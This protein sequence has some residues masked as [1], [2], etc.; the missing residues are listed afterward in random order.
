MQRAK[1]I[2]F[3]FIC[4]LF[5]QKSFATHII[6]GEIFYDCTGGNNYKITMKV[7]RDC[8]N[9]I[10][11]PFDVPASVF[12]FDAQGNFIDSLEMI[13]PQI[14]ILPVTINNPCASA[15]V[16]ICVEEAIYSANI[17]LPNKA[18]GYDIVYQRCCR[19]GTILNLV[20]PGAVGS[21]FMTHIPDP[22]LALCNSSPRFKTFP[23][24]FLCINYPLNYD[25]SAI[26]PDGDSL[27]YELC[28]PYTGLSATC[29]I[30]GQAAVAAGCPGIPTPPPYAFVP[31]S[32][33]YTSNNPM[34]ANPALNIN[35]STGLM[36]GTPNML[37]QWVVGVCVKEY[38]K[39]VLIN[40]S[41]RDFQFNVTNC[42]NL[43]VAA[44]ISQTTFC[45]GYNV[46]FN[47][48]STNAQ[49]F[50][51]DFGVASTS[52]DTSNV[53]NPS[54]T[55]ADSGTYTVTLI[56]NPNTP[57]ADTQKSSFYIYP[58]LNP[59]LTSPPG[60][61]FNGHTFNLTPGGSFMG[62]GSTFNWNFG[63]NATPTTSSAQNPSN[64]TFNAP[65]TYTVSLTVTENGCTKTVTSTINVFPQPVAHFGAD[66][67]VGCSMQPISFL[68]SSSTQPL[69]YLWNFGNGTTSTL[70]NPVI[71][72]NTNGTY[73]VSLIVT[74]SDG[75]KDTATLASPITTYPSPVAGFTVNPKDTTM[76]F[77]TITMYDASTGA[78]GCTVFWGDGSSGINCNDVH[79][80]TSPG[81][82]LI[83]QVV[84]NAN[85]C[86]DTA[87]S[88][89]LIRPEFAFWIPNA[90]TPNGNGLNDVFKPVIKGVSN[91][92]FLIF[93]R[94]GE[95]LFET[96]NINVGWDG[97][98]KGKLCT[99][100][101][102]VYKVSFMDDE[103][104]TDKQYIGN[105][106]LVR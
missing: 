48:T 96:N 57:C 88:T 42:P 30:L 45:F 12:I 82:Y 13:S 68:D 63:A 73:S 76:A 18:G 16:G 91:Y 53:P 32:S 93:D 46:Q 85:G 69:T 99:N 86:Y 64:V 47:Q 21:T 74:N 1:K 100:D 102:Y 10:N 62:N 49:T 101:V 11:A 79:T 14:K 92:K 81:T 39:G 28:D 26:D 98:Y 44:I 59:T 106:T 40:T 4:I 34:S 6:G 78:T 15:P 38:R 70:Q 95:K 83:M 7:Y 75:C 67:Q 80:Y 104:Y 61:C 31:F 35:S 24:I 33:P 43:P 71:T 65:G 89:V 66:G 27:V 87:Y 2:F 5:V 25:H 60:K 22:A 56:I 36:T 19:N 90:F 55:Y 29:P 77:P 84:V 51:W 58:L 3:F 105:V 94:W 50:H 20:N 41:K 103:T 17:V 37:G 54:Y 97:T 23:P 8:T 72:Y 52:N 9:P